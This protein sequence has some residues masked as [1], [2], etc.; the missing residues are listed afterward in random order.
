MGWLG[1]NVGSSRWSATARQANGTKRRQ[2]TEGQE[3][4][5]STGAGT[6]SVQSVE[7]GLTNGRVLGCRSWVFGLS[8]SPPCPHALVFNSN[9]AR[10]S[11]VDERALSDATAQEQA[12]ANLIIS[13]D[14]KR[15]RDGM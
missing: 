15:K 11:D 10:P 1:L 13:F 9:S 2:T 7:S 6:T 3:T 12:R 14:R 5:V 4:V 8:S